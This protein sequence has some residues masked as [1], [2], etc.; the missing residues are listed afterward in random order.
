MIGSRRYVGSGAFLRSARGGSTSP[1]ASRRPEQILKL[2]SRMNGATVGDLQR[3]LDAS[4]SEVA[5]QLNTLENLD[6]V[7]AGTE[8]VEGRR[9][10]LS[11][12]GQRA[13]QLSYFA[14]A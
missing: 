7:T 2:I 6:L 11:P 4:P 8:A 5:A 10:V 9:Y 1:S 14:V 3:E 13:L 12:T